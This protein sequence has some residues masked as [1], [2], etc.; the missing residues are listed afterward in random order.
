MWE[1]SSGQLPFM[2]YNHDHN[3]AINIIN[4]MRPKILPN[5]PSKYKSL[6]EQCWDANPLKRPNTYTL[7][8][9][10]KEI[11]SY[12]QNN[13]NE[14]PQQN[15]KINE[16]G[17]NL[18]SNKLF[19]SK[20]YRFENLP[21]PKNATEDND[22]E[23]PRS[24]K[25]LKLENV[26]LKSE[27]EI[28]QQ[29]SN[30]DINDD[31]HNNPNLRSEKQDINILK[32]FQIFCVDISGGE[33][34]KRPK[35]ATNTGFGKIK[36]C[37]VLNWVVRCIIDKMNKNFNYLFNGTLYLYNINIQRETGTVRSGKWGKHI[38]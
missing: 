1:I 33:I 2:N 27:R 21:E 15:V 7:L 19:T 9:K 6:M 26:D 3:L 10:I 17:N 18:M 24:F 23:S 37:L 38:G 25:R 36:T 11:M 14:L 28:T 34:G 8:K 35:K 20:I 16:E 31:V 13:P 12:Y 4:G 5:I 32:N 29:R 30:I 22:K